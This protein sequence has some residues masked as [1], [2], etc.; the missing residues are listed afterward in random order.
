MSRR[1]RPAYCGGNA[2]GGKLEI[3]NRR[4]N[5]L[6][7]GASESRVFRITWNDGTLKVKL[8]HTPHL[9]YYHNERSTQDP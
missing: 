2:C 7:V 5:R 1:M 6:F 8:I 3:A 4:H 9:V